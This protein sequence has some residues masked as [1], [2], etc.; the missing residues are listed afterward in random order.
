MFSCCYG[1][2]VIVLSWQQNHFQSN[3]TTITLSEHQIEP[4]SSKLF[5]SHVASWQFKMKELIELG[6]KGD[7]HF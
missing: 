7:T 3:K 6:L 5:Q 4:S 1:C 2:I